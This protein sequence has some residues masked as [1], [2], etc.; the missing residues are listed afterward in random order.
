[1]RKIAPSA[2]SGSYTFEMHQSRLITLLASVNPQPKGAAAKERR[3]RPTFDPTTSMNESRTAPFVWNLFSFI[4]SWHGG[5]RS[6]SRSSTK[7]TKSGAS[8]SGIEDGKVV[9]PG[10]GSELV[11]AVRK[12]K[13]MQS[14]TSRT[15]DRTRLMYE[16]DPL[17]DVIMTLLHSPMSHRRPSHLL[18][19][20]ATTKG[21]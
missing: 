7:S 21:R 3:L 15:Q 14:Q 4:Q 11:P 2:I 13:Q 18:L 12:E 5:D 10:P 19:T 20:R 1:M 16:L 6:G 9:E 17:W 8:T